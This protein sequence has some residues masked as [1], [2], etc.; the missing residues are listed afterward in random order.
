MKYQVQFIPEAAKDYKELDGSIKTLVR[1]KIEEIELNP[2]LGEKLGNKFN[3]DLTGFLK[4]Y[5]ASKKYRIVYRLIT[6]VKVEIV[7]VWGIGKR[8]KEEIYRT[9]GRRLG[10]L[11]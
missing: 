10:K 2:F 8:E 11:K 5:V 6:P 7:E 4:T 9:I 3:I 1:K